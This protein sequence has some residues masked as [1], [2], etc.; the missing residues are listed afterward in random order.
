MKISSFLLLA[1]LFINST[2]AQETG[3]VGIGTSTPAQKLDVNGS[4]ELPVTINSTTGILF[5]GGS[6]FLHDFKASSAGSIGQNVFLGKN[7]GNFTM[8]GG[9]NYQS[10]DNT[11]IGTST[12][13]SNTTG[14]ANTSIGSFSMPTNSTGY[15]NTAIGVYSLY[16]NLTGIENT[17]MGVYSAQYNSSGNSNVTIGF[18]ANCF[19]QTGSNNTI[20]G[21]SAGSGTSVHNKSGNVFIGYQAGYFETGSNKLYIENSNSITPLIGAD[22][23]LDQVYLNGAVGIGTSTPA[24]SAKLEIAG[25]DKGFLPPRLTTAQID[26]ISGP[27]TGLMVYNSTLN[28][29]QFFDGNEWRNFDG[30][31]YIGENFGGGI[32]FYTDGTGQHGLIASPTDQSADATWGC[33][34][35]LIGATATA[36]GSGQANTTAID[37]G[38][39]ETWIA[40]H[41]CNNLVLNSYDDWF[42]P[43]FDELNEMYEQRNVIG[44]GIGYYWSSS[45]ADYTSAW[46][47]GFEGYNIF[48]VDKGSTSSVRAIRAF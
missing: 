45:E 5:K 11:G 7:A 48:Q 6:P 36:I 44:A 2:L 32:V 21:Y 9:V 47:I 8:P 18:N 41:I 39:P 43:S 17:S 37:N 46:A 3:N 35:T 23:S 4:I 40:A 38:C 22:F 1:V 14:F 19:N 31:H 12:L 27:A 30:T 10:S 28:K 16:S 29:P 25:T 42:L 33:W 24:A 20:V 26:A 13:F 15:R 34:M